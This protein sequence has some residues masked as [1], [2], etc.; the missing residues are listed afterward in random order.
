LAILGLV[1]AAP[2]AWY[3]GY[4]AWD[5]HRVRK[6]CRVVL[7]GMS[8]AEARRVVAD[9]G[10]ERYLRGEGVFDEKKGTWDILVPAGSTLGDLTC[11]IEH[12]GKTVVA[13]QLMG[14]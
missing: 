1:V 6:V 14:P 12:N 11:F 3:S 13:T 8:V 2:I 7:P 9:Y 10:L 5:T 4:Y